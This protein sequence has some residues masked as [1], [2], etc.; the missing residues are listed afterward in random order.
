VAIRVQWVQRDQGIALVGAIVVVLQTG[1]PGADEIVRTESALSRAKAEKQRPVLV[2]VM[3]RGQGAGGLPDT[4]AREAMARLASDP[5]E[6]ALVLEPRGFLGAALR[7]GVSALVQGARRSQRTWV[8]ATLE[9]AAA[10]IAEARP[11]LRPWLAELPTA[12]ETLT[13]QVEALVL[14]R[15]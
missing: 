5:I 6:T 15:A 12:L 3:R 4:S 2:V 7:A 11:E 8:V 14:A 1:P 10:A 13:A 9:E